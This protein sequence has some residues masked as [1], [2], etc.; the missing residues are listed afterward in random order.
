MTK[1]KLC[2]KILTTRK[3]Y[4]SRLCQNRYQAKFKNGFKGK[5]HSVETKNKMRKNHL[6]RIFRN[7][8]TKT[9]DG[10]GYIFIYRPN[11]LD[12]NKIGYIRE[13]RFVMAEHLQ[14][15][16][17]KSEIVHHIDSDRSN[18]KIENL[19]LFSSQ[20]EHVAFH[21]RLVDFIVKKYGYKIITEYTEWLSNQPI[22]NKKRKYKGRKELG[23][24]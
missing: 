5:H 13:H 14:R 17:L 3:V 8:N 19:M 18:N 11:N 1:C 7:K 16:L 2:S 22:L 6:G 23:D 10:H 20:K 21:C 24:K 12:C 9:K 15:R 4:C